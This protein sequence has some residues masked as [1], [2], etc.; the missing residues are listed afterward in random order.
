MMC[1]YRSHVYLHS[2]SFPPSP[3]FSSSISPCLSLPLSASASLPPSSARVIKPLAQRTVFRGL[4]LIILFVYKYIADTVATYFKCVALNG[5]SRYPL[6]L[7][8][9]LP[10]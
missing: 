4:W 9:R 1:T 7:V 10:A 3:F 8:S 5:D 6:K 2:F